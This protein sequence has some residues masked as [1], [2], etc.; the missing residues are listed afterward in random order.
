MSEMTTSLLNVGGRVL[1]AI[2]HSSFS[3]GVSEL[4]GWAGVRLGAP[5]ELLHVLDRHPETARGVD[6]TGTIGLGAREDLLQELAAL[7]EQHSRLAQQ[8]AVHLLEGARQRAAAAGATQVE[9]RMRHGALVETLTELETDVRLFVIGRRGTHADRARGH[10]GSNLER[11]VRAVHRPV[12]VSP[13]SFEPP[14]NVLIAF[15]GQPTA[16]KAVE[17]VAQSPLFH[18][19]P[20]H[21]VMAGTE[22]SEH[23]AQLADARNRLTAAGFSVHASIRPGR[24]ETVLGEYVKSEGISLLVMGA[25]GHSQIRQLL[26]GSTTTT[27]LRTCEVPVLLLR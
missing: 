12:L 11:V 24:P 21:L 3:A 10:L 14:R 20:L 6:L 2:D 17:M 27:L 7:D 19:L 4:A 26:V 9:T 5:V 15:D 25:Y 23:Q 8:R 22:S 1:A 18:G 16:R 13:E